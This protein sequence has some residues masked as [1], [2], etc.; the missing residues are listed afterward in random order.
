LINFIPFYKLIDQSSQMS[1]PMSS[2][3]FYDMVASDEE[4]S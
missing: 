3:D 2:Y 1:K 4:V